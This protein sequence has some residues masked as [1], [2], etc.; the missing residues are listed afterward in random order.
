MV[1][2]G[3]H[4]CEMD[5]SCHFYHFSFVALQI[6]SDTSGTKSHY[7]RKCIWRQHCETDHFYHFF[8]WRFKY[9]PMHSEEA[10]FRAIRIKR[11]RVKMDHFYHFPYRAFPGRTISS[12]SPLTCSGN[13]FDVRRSKKK[14]IHC[15]T[16]DEVVRTR[17]FV[18]RVQRM[19]RLLVCSY[20]FLVPITGAPI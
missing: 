13:V 3:R 17:F 15:F 12:R 8:K 14:T 16:R 9:T 2:N 10:Q 7:R 18:R 6:N 11:R 4:Q 5:H 1:K 20:L 19:K